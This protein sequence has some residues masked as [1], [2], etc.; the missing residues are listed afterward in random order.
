VLRRLSA[1][2][3]HHAFWVVLR[4]AAVAAEFEVL[5]PAL[6]G[7]RHADPGPRGGIRL[8]RRLV[9]GLIA[10]R[11]RPDSRSGALMTATG[12]AFFPPGPGG[13]STRRSRGALAT[14]LVDIWSVLFVALL[15]SYLT[16]GRRALLPTIAGSFVLLV[17][18]ALLIK[19]LATATCTTARSSGWSRSRCSCG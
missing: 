17:Y 18:A 11:R 10:W 19:D 13:R 7:P 12:F 9:R 3:R 6:F 4:T 14:W 16:A 1:R 8:C 2:K 5:R 15:V